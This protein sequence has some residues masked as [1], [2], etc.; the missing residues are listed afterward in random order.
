[1]RLTTL[2]GLLLSASCGFLLAAASA[3]CGGDDM[4]SEEKC[5]ADKVSGSSTQYATS[6]LRL[7]Q[8]SGSKTYAYDFNKDGKTENQLKTLIQAV[9]V[10][11]L[12]LQDSVSKA[13]ADGEAV[14]LGELKASDLTS[15]NCAGVTLSLADPPAMGAKPP[16]FDGSDTF[17]V[18]KVMGVKLYG[19]ITDGKLST[20]A[21][22]DQAAED[23]QRIEINLPLAMGMNLPL[24][25]RGVHI[26]GTV[27]MDK[28][29]PVLKDGQ[30]H[31]VISQKDIDGKIVPL[32]AKLVSGLVNKDPMGSSTKTIVNLFENQMNQV[33]KD[34]CMNTPAKCCKTNP[35][36]CEILDAEIKLSP[37]GSVLSSD[38]EAFDSTDRWAPSKENKN[39]NGMSVGLGFSMIKAKF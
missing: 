30:L 1:M 6:D 26:E 4:M 3:G 24:A 25:L 31:G 35:M 32:V 19:K 10:A 13:V 28:G 34:K 33:S 8:S 27:A 29:Q 21:S 5:T 18:G 20:T 11:G 12:N 9:T 16:V 39:K 38:I 37:V 2:H 36:T 23:E 7:P 17:K 14:I 22:A 15:T